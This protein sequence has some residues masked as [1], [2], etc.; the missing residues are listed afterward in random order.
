[1]AGLSP[2]YRIVRPRTVLYAAFIAVVSSVMLYALVGRSAYSLAVI[3]DRNPLYVRLSDGAIR[4]AYTVRFVNKY[5][6]AH[7]LTLG[8]AGLDN[9]TVEIIGS[10]RDSSSREV[11]E[12]GPDQ[13]REVRVLVVTRSKQ[14]ASSLP[15]TFTAFNEDDAAAAT[16][17]D[18]FRTP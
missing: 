11:I 17:H 16:A 6:E 15:V 3:H 13:T 18:F 10:G 2:V 14:Q 7:R 5:S 12:V 1:M 9:A 8:L 4:N